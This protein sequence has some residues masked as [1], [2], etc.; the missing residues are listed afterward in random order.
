MGNEQEAKSHIEEW[1]KEAKRQKD[2][3]EQA[4][5]KCG[6]IGLSGAGK[7]SLIN[8]IAGEK[9]APVGSTE[10]T[11]QAQSYSHQGIEFV[12]LPGCGTARWPQ[13]TYIHDLGLAQYDCFIIV[14]HTRLYEADLFLLHE[15][16]EKQHKPCF[17][18]RNKIDVAITDEAHDNLLTEQQTLDKVRHNLLSSLQLPKLTVYLTSARYPS[19]WDLPQLMDDISASQQGVKRDRFI[20]GM[21]LW[22]TR[23]FEQKAEVVNKIIS[24]AAVAAAA[25]GINPVPLLNVS[26]DVGILT[27]MCHQINKIYALTP[28]QLAYLEAAAPQLRHSPEFDG[29]KQAITRWLAKYAVAEGVLS[30]LKNMGKKVVIRNVASFLPVVGTLVSVGVGYRMTVAFGEH[31]HEEARVLARQLLERIIAEQDVNTAAG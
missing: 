13:Q 26:V 11:M 15:L 31:Y 16:R 8:A 18:V 21:A 27:T 29:L 22:S 9:I 25:N 24:W 10:Q 23:A 30:V 17:V 2:A 20:A 7:S 4:S 28:E 1:L 14:T 6:I 19:R 3:F 12:D 5:V